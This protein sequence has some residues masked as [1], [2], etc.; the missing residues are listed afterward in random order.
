MKRYNFFFV[1]KSIIS[2]NAFE[3]FQKLPYIFK[4]KVF[5]SDLP[6]KNG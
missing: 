1:L 3:A 4:N 6:M 2:V 5:E